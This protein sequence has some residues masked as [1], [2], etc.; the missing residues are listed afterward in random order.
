MQN[1]SRHNGKTPLHTIDELAALGIQL[2]IFPG[3]MVRVIA[4]AAQ[5]YLEALRR[6]GSTQGILDQMFD[7]RGVNEVIGTDAM[8][9]AG[10][11]YKD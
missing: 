7:F 3:A 2:A 6:D 5:I 4:R 1:P 10:D 11:K 9:A 8:L